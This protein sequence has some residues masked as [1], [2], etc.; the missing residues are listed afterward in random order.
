[1]VIR[2]RAVASGYL[3]GQQ[4]DGSNRLAGGI[5]TDGLS[6]EAGRQ[7]TSRSAQPG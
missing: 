1:M 5:S 6:S 2:G 4:N 7:T 3:A